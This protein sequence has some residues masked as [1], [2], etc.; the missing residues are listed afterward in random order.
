[1]QALFLELIEGQEKKLFNIA[2][3]IIPNI[4]WDDLLQPNDYPV[5]ENNP[6][7]RYEEG[8]LEGL[9]TA[10]MAFLANKSH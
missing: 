10:Y 5:L 2:Q 6:Y 3:R 1:M 9:R 7:F 8:I 4:T